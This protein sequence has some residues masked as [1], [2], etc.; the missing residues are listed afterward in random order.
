MNACY[1]IMNAGRQ[2]WLDW[3]EKTTWYLNSLKKKGSDS[4]WE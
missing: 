3:N 1:A 2:R 4:T